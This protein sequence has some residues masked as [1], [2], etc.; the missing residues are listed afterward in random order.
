MTESKKISPRRKTRELVV[1]GLYQW[2]LTGHDRL[3][4]EANFREEDPDFNRADVPMFRTLLAGILTQVAELEALVQPHLDRAYAEI[5]PIERGIMLLAAY[6][7][8][9]TPEVPFRVLMNEAIELA[10]TF[11]GTDAHKYVNGVLDKLGAVLR[12]AEAA[13][14][15]D[16]RR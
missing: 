14:P 1:Q 3:A 10:K 16:S 9:D 5:N 13:A 8:R 4:I 7:M 6:E 12:T 2:Q 11:G 15:R